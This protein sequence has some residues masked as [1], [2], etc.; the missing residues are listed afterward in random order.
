MSSTA[1]YSSDPN[2]NDQDTDRTSATVL[3]HHDVTDALQ[4]RANLRYSALTDGFGY[5]YLAEGT[6]PDGTI[7][8]RAYFG[9]DRDVRELVGN[10][11]LQYDAQ[12][13]AFDSSTLA[14]IEFNDG[15][16]DVTAAFGA[17]SPIDIANPVNGPDAVPATYLDETRD[18]LTRSA[19]V[20]QNLSFDDRIIA[21]VGLRRDWLELETTSRLTGQTAQAD[22]AETSWRGALTYKV[23][24]AL[25]VYGSYVES[26]APPSIGV[27]P[28]RGSQYEV[29]VKYE[30]AGV[31][32]I[33]SAAVFDLTKDNVSASVVQGDGTIRQQL[34]GA[35]RARGFEVEGK[36]ELTDSLEVIAGYSY[37]DTEVERGTARGVDVT[38]DTFGT[39]PTHTASV[40][41]NYTQPAG[42]VLNAQTFGG[43]VRYVGD[44]FYG[45]PNEGKSDAAL[46]VDASYGY[47]LEEDAEVTVNVSNLFDEQHVVGAGTAN[48]Y[49]PGRSIAVTL[50]QSW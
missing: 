38:G 28:E 12:F 25:S 9:Q 10:V 27:E 7:Y 13:A 43:G 32:G 39:V 19:F 30:P 46:L 47:A 48:Y 18:A 17:A 23:S 42:E 21:T 35:Y 14:G 16:S 2:Q 29:G 31:N 4:L 37:I 6:G 15:Q 22:Y 11:I 33:V 20:Q 1:N 36:A 41:V 3:A 24:D 44:Y 49:N 40:W 5:V 45:I 26:V 50:R 34:I 8:N